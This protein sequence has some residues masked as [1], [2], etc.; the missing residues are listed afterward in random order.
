[1]NYHL[2][3]ERGFLGSALRPYCKGNQTSPV[4][5]NCMAK[6]MGIKGNKEHPATMMTENLKSAIEVFELAVPNKCKRIINFGSTCA[7]AKNAFTPFHPYMYMQGEPEATNYGYAMAKR[8]IYALSNVYSQEFG[9]DNLYLVMPNLYGPGCHFR[10]NNHVI[11]EMIMKIQKA[12]DQHAPQIVF[13][14]T[15]SAQREFLYIEDAVKLV[16]QAIEECHTPDLVHLTSGQL[17]TIRDLAQMLC[18]IMGFAGSIGWDM[19]GPDG[20][21]RRQLARGLQ[22]EHDTSLE[23]GLAATVRYYRQAIYPQVANAGTIQ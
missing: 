19:V 6:V 14:G 10:P 8:A 15:G 4:W 3:G 20:Q 9:M 17:I 11:P 21:M 16:L 5:I 22:L 1:M 2:F 13:M 23:E 18:D 12:L 7:Y